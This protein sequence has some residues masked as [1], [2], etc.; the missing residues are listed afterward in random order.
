MSQINNNTEI[1]EQDT[2][3]EIIWELKHKKTFAFFWSW[4]A[5]IGYLI[6]GIGFIVIVLEKFL[7]K[8]NNGWLISVI[9]VI[10]IILWFLQSPLM[11]V[12]TLNLKKMFIKNDNLILQKY[13]GKDIKITLG[14]FYVNITSPAWFAALL[15][16]DDVSIIDFDGKILYNLELIEDNIENLDKFYNILKPFITD[17]LLSLDKESFYNIYNILLPLTRDFH[18][19]FYQNKNQIDLDKIKKLRKD[20]EF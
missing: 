5:R 6:I 18:S 12:K 3:D 20:E 13:I 10:L 2:Q 8:N 17:F 1:K 16:C 4:I 14:S 11:L 7:N 19:N 9:L 15:A